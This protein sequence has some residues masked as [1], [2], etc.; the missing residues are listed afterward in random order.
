MEVKVDSQDLW[1]ESCVLFTFIVFLLR[2]LEDLF[3]Y[4]KIHTS[5]HNVSS[6]LSK[7]PSY[8]FLSTSSFIPLVND[9]WMSLSLSL[10]LWKRFGGKLLFE[11]EFPHSQ[12][13]VL[14]TKWSVWIERDR[15]RLETLSERKREREAWDIVRKKEREREREILLTR[16]DNKQNFSPRLTIVT[17]NIHHFFTSFHHHELYKIFVKR[18]E[19]SG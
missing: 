2:I 10:S 19:S 9:V 14:Q 13:Q 3:R 5:K 11:S 18:N 17:F 7:C 6:S 12:P 16:T 8:L 1:V 15:M 4:P